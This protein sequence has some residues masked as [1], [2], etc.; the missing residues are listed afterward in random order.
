MNYVII[1]ASSIAGRAAVDAVRAF[2]AKAHV[3]GTT[4]GD[5]DLDHCDETIG[6]L[7]LFKDGAVEI[8]LNALSGRDIAAIFYTPSMGMVGHP[9]WEAKAA[10]IEQALAFSYRPLRRLGN[11]LD[12]I[13]VGYSSF[14]W[15]PHISVAYGAMAAA[16]FCIESLAVHQPERF[17]VIRSGVFESKSLRG[18]SLMVRRELK[19]TSDPHLRA[20]EADWKSR[21][22]NFTEY[23]FEFAHGTERDTF[24]H[25]PRFQNIPH[26]K[27]S[28]DDLK[29]AALAVLKNETG[30]IHNIIGDWRWDEDSLPEVRPEILKPLQAFA[31]ETPAPLGISAG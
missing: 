19:S 15:L 16:K 14:F 20:L 3:I 8:I 10:D 11:E 18:I 23:F 9:A 13:V 29:A 5:N 26:R 24:Q 28:H 22:C 6:G 30:P 31:S 17:R 7:D 2:S 27:T 25:D 12:T 1:G 21:G 4:S